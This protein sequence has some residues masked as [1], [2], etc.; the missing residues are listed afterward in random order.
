MPFAPRL[1]A[2]RLQRIRDVS[3]AQTSFQARRADTVADIPPCAGSRPGTPR[4]DR[5]VPRA[6][7]PCRERSHPNLRTEKYSFG[8]ANI[9]PGLSETEQRDRRSGHQMQRSSEGE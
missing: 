6:F 8:L 9:V 5:G 7:V 3:S 4:A 2:S 1:D